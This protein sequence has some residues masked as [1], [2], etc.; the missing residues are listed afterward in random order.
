[1]PA[2]E[3]NPRV[4]R[5]LNRLFALAGL[6]R[7]LTVSVPVPRTAKNAAM[8][9]PVPPELPPGV[10]VWSYGFTVCPP[11]E[12]TESPSRAISCRFVFPSIIAPA[13]FKAL[14]TGASSAGCKSARARQPPVVFIS[15]VS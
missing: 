4:G 10:R 8:A 5:I 12:D 1:M 6:R 9:A 3:I 7:E 15:L 13:F 2:L 14:T 11:R